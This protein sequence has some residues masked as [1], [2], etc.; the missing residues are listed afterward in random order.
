MVLFQFSNCVPKL[1]QFSQSGSARLRR[2]SWDAETR[3]SLPLFRHSDVTAHLITEQITVTVW[4][5]L[6]FRISAKSAC[7][8]LL[9]FYLSKVSMLRLL[10]ILDD[11]SLMLPIVRF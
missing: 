4:M 2:I 7:L 6:D 8:F 10:P 1:F 11:C 3:A 9:I 5:I